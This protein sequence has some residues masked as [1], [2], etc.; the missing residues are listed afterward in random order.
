MR[1]GSRCVDAV[2]AIDIVGTAAALDVIVPAEAEDGVVTAAAVDRVAAVGDAVERIEG[3]G[4]VGT[5]DRG[6]AAFL[7]SEPSCALGLVSR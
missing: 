3:L 7:L 1:S 4:V 5:V 2:A 6:H